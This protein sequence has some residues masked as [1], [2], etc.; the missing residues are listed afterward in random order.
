M[1]DFSY[2]FPNPLPNWSLWLKRESSVVPKQTHTSHRCEQTGCG[3]G[4][5][6][7]CGGAQRGQQ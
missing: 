2:F 3:P 7:L 6:D 4:G 1:L 5:A